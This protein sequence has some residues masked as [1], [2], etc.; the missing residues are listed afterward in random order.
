MG[1][2]SV[3]LVVGGGSGIGRS[4]CTM[5]HQAGHR[6]LSV[7]RHLDE[8]ANWE[9]GQLDIRDASALATYFADLRTQGV[10]IETLVVT[11]G[12]VSPD[13][14]QQISHEVASSILQ[15]NVLSAVA[16]VAESHDLIVES[17]SIILFSSVAASKGGGLFGAS[18]YAAS[19]A[20]LEGLT[21]GL[22]RELSDRRIRVNC[23]APGPTHTAILADASMETRQRVADATFLG[24]FAEADEIADVVM[25]L[26]GSRASFIT[27]EV[28]AVDGGARVK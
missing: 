6:V 27:G 2:P 19:K 16:L 28:I 8:S 25:F 22:A 5:A 10:R 24:R 1:D 9:A 4:V 7:D 21:R 12:I 23:I 14:I 11:A 15:T 3:F 13:P 17:G 26:C 20:A 18:V